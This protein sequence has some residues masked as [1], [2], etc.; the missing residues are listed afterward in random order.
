M[1]WRNN[2]R[3]KASYPGNMSPFIACSE[4]TAARLFLNIHRKV[5]FALSFDREAAGR[6]C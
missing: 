2:P 3:N 4:T 5:I 6:G 1:F